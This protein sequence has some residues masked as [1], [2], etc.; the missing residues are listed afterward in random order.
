MGG[1]S[2]TPL[3]LVE[4]ERLWATKEA[5]RV[6]E[7]LKQVKPEFSVKLAG[8]LGN[9]T[10]AGPDLI[11]LFFL[12]A[13]HEAKNQK[14]KKDRK[15]FGQFVMSLPNKDKMKRGYHYFKLLMR[16]K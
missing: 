13:N 10:I 2:R 8:I 9:F 12:T 3:K 15:D 5:N 16:L 14:K 1:F 11:D 6:L 4:F 7:Q